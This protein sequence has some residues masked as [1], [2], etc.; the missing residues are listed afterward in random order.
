MEKGDQV[1]ATQASFW[2]PDKSEM[3]EMAY[4]FVVKI[5]FWG[6]MP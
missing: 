2:I 1:Q 4:P 5:L 3:A 6:T